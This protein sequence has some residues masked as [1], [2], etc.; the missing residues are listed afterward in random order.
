MSRCTGGTY[1][2][3]EFVTNEVTPEVTHQR[4]VFFLALDSTRLI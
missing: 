3:L 1:I 2:N 4:E